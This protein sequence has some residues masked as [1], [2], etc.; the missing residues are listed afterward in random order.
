MTHHATIAA[1]ILLFLKGYIDTFYY[2]ILLDMHTFIYLFNKLKNRIYVEY[3]CN[4]RTFARSGG[5]S[6]IIRILSRL[7]ICCMSDALNT[8]SAAFST[9]K[10][11]NK[12][13]VV[14]RILNQHLMR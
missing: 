13:K 7:C 5:F 14:E 9:Y 12:V 3:L 8:K 1:I 11:H 6:N 2:V 10:I 4:A